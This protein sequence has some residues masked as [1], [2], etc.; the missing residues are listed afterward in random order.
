ML[1]AS[2]SHFSNTSTWSAP[3]KTEQ[4]K[5]EVGGARGEGGGRKKEIIYTDTQRDIRRQ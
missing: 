5:R 2:R 1:E 4:G 3:D